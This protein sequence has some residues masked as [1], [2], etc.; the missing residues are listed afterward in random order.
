MA[1]LHAQ[2]VWESKRE[3]VRAVELTTYYNYLSK[4]IFSKKKKKKSKTNSLIQ[5][6]ILHKL[7][8]RVDSS[9]R[10]HKFFENKILYIISWKK[11]K[12]CYKQRKKHDHKHNNFLQLCKS[13]IQNLKSLLNQSQVWQPLG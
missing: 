8:S 11:K 13:G 6:K 4:I 9:L 7:K 2:S 10:I 1:F 12:F 5:K 3:R